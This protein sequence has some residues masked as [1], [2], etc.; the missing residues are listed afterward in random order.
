[1]SPVDVLLALVLVPFAI[2]GWRRGLCREGFDLVGVVGGL[3]V[4]A[5]AAP[6]I[7]GALAAHAI[8][9]LLAYPIA[10]AAVLVAVMV[11]ARVI[12]AVVAN[13]LH[14]ILLGGVDRTAGFC[15]GALKGAACLGLILM[16]LDRLAPTPAVQIAI[17]GSVLGPSLMRVA[18]S[19]LA[20]GREI[21]A[22]ASGV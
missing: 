4:G 21:S 15:F 20:F 5:A 17:Q 3:I 2:H 11:G 10:L 12:G 6:T 18:T 1:M 13:G 8:P 19:A 22:V 7:G 16:L 14:A 9:H